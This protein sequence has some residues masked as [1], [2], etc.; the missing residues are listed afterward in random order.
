MCGI[1]GL[2]QFKV[3]RKRKDIL[4]LLFTGLRR[5]EYRGYDSAGISIDASA[6]PD[7]NGDAEQNGKGFLRIEA[8]SLN[9]DADAAELAHA[10]TVYFSPRQKSGG[11]P[12]VVKS[13]GK[14]DALVE[15]TYTHLRE[16]N[17]DLETVLSD[18]CGI[19]HT[20]WATHGAPSSI[21]SH[22][23]TSGP[24]NE[25]LVV[26][27]GIITNYKALKDF[28]V[29]DKAA[30]FQ[31]AEVMWCCSAKTAATTLLQPV[32]SSCSGTTCHVTADEAGRAL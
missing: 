13:L 23:H 31:F 9:D 21:N 14:V 12:L 8:N 11:E 20:R 19:A 32:V 6:E 15:L 22:P 27:N 3:K 17:V 7:S 4:E 28:L 26:H 1:F 25:F 29:R 18:H 2:Y 16:H 24:D 10:P 5:L 30:C